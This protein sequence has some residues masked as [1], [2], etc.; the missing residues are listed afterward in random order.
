M[1]IYINGE[2][3]ELTKEQLDYLYLGEGQEGVTYI[4]KDKALKIYKSYSSI[5]RLSE[6]EALYLSKIPTKRILMPIDLV[7]DE[8]GN[9]IGYTT[10]FIQNYNRATIK[11]LPISK[12]K[13]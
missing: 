11:Q 9:F 2:R 3:I 6:K 1:I 5:N 4:Y 13:E 12:I 7:Y 8:N 10:K